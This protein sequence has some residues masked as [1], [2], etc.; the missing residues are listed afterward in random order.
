MDEPAEL[1]SPDPHGHV[2]HETTDASAFYVGLFA[3]GLAIM[4]ALA[5]LFLVWLFWRFEASAERADPVQSPLA[6]NQL[7]PAPRLQAQPSADLAKLRHEEDE[8]LGS[9]QWIDQ[10]QGIVQLPIDRAI[11]L[12][13]EQGLAEP[14]V[15]STS[16]KQEPVP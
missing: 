15:E 1:K 13:A 2:G 11:E 5:L 3:L 12:L 4:I 7:P 9:Y 6:V 8:R 16:T 14:Q 10:Q